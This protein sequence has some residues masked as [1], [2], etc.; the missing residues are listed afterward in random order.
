MQLGR[1]L[2]SDNLGIFLFTGPQLLINAL[3]I[4]G[5][6]PLF[7][8]SKTPLHFRKLV[9]AYFSLIP[10]WPNYAYS[11]LKDSLY[12]AMILLFLLLM[13]R[14]IRD[15]EVFCGKAGNQPF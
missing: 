12:M 14:L 13:M 6:F 8:E 9:L 5:Y 4:A 11:L 15:P 3:V 1:T 2:G 7:K 10:I